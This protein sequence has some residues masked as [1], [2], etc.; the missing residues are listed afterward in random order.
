MKC[1][2]KRTINLSCFRP[3]DS[4]ENSPTWKVNS[5]STIKKYPGFYDSHRPRCCSKPNESEILKLFPFLMPLEVKSWWL[6]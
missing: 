4:T 1:H 2:W 3:S 6:L 5:H